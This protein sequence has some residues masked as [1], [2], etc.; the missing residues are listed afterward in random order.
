MNG[1]RNLGV[2]IAL[3]TIVHAGSATK[4]NQLMRLRSR[5]LLAAC[6]LALMPSA[7]LADAAAEMARKLQNPL[8]NMKAIMTDNA[9]G[10]DTGTDKGTSYGFQIQPV[11][12]IDVPERGFTFIPRAVMP[13]M[14]LEPGTDVPPV[15]QDGQPTPPGTTRVWGLG[16][17]MLQFF[18]APH[19]S[20]KV[21]WG[22]GPQISLPTRTDSAFKGPDWGAGIAGVITGAITPRLT[23]AA[24]VSNHWSFDGKF[25]LA[26]VQ[27][28]VYFNV[29]D[30]PGVAVSYNAPITADWKA[31]S[32]NRWTVPLGLTVSKTLDMGD[33][34]GLDLGIGPY[35]NV[36]RPEGAAR[37]QLRFGVT[38]IFP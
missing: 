5:C 1:R 20:S 19:T 14:G 34:H 2:G 16:D 26:T 12:A 4:G 21:K 17:S 27:P 8:A 6:A 10:F 22:I 36:A 33:G 18:F 28:T 30:M 38:W 24:I 25:N 13:I 37:W 23:Y 7:A 29:P 35:Y 31:S 9:I 15:G 32:G 11:Y 3:T